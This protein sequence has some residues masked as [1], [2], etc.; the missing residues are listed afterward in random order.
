MTKSIQRFHQGTRG[1]ADIAYNWLVHPDGTVLEG[2]GLGV[3]SAANGTNTGN[4]SSP[5]ICMLWGEGQRLTPEA[6]ASLEQLIKWLADKEGIPN[7]A[8]P[9]SSWKATSC[10]GDE[11]RAFAKSYTGQ[12][13]QITSPS[14]VE[15]F[16][17]WINARLKEYNHK[18]PPLVID[19][20]YGPK[21]RA[22]AQLVRDTYR[23]DRARKRKA[24]EKEDQRLY[25]EENH[26]TVTMNR[27]K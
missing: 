27:L 13:T 16:Q 5:A 23:L 6:K 14:E 21:S 7:K 19:G 10:P 26:A 15:A 24:F 12:V 8:R 20:D 18:T 17:K 11:I 25:L 9:H 1:W 2:R 22:A 3:R 4:S